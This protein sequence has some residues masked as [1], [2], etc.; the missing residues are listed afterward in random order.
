MFRKPRASVHLESLILRW[1]NIIK[2]D[3]GGI[4]CEDIEF[5]VP[6][7]NIMRRRT[8][9]NSAINNQAICVTVMELN[10]TG[11]GI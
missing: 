10:M 6:K 2:T 1:K 7:N 9:V 8:F 5:I 11:V 3:I 4:G